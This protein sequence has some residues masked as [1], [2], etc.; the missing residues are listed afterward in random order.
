[1]HGRIFNHPDEYGSMHNTTDLI[2]LAH[3]WPHMKY[4]EYLLPDLLTEWNTNKLTE[5][6][7]I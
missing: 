1:M 4:L 7:L 2:A 3:K 5:Y 6:W